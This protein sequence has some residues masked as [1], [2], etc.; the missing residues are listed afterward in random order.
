MAQTQ[1]RLVAAP[2]E[3]D[4]VPEVRAALARLAKDTDPGA[5]FLVTRS[6]V[7]RVTNDAHDPTTFHLCSGGDARPTSDF[8]PLWS[9]DNRVLSIGG[10]VVKRYGRS[11]PNQEAVLQAFQEQGWPCRI[12]DPLPYSAEVPPKP[13]LHDTIRWLNLNHEYPLLRFLGDGTGEGVCWKLVAS[14]GLILHGDPP[15]ELRPAA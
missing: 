7:L 9:R 8:T 6:G 13:R 3:I 10:Q 11:S 1:L 4:I 2:P 5:C 14:R 12:D 15:E